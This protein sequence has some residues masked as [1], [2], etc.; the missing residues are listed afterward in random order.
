[1]VVVLTLV[2]S[3]LLLLLSS[4]SLLL[5]VSLNAINVMNVDGAT[6]DGAFGN[7]VFN[8]YS[9]IVSYHHRRYWLW[10]Y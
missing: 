5:F 8:L 3:L 10:F 1:M 9:V 7:I 4:S 6:G 2:S